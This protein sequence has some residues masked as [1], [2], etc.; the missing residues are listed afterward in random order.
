MRELLKNR[1]FLRF[2]S[3]R[4]VTNIG[5]SLYLIG[6]LWLVHDLTGSTLYTGAAGF[7]LRAPRLIQFLFGPLVDRWDLRKTL[8]GTQLIQGVF[9]LSLPV[10]SALNLLSVWLVLAVI[11]TLATVSRIQYPT[12]TA[13]L[14]RI[15][16]DDQLVRANSLF[17]MSGRTLDIVF[18]ATAGVLIAAVGVTQLFVIDAVTFGIATLLFLGV[19]LRTLE[20][21]EEAGGTPAATDGGEPADE[22]GQVAEYL[23]ELKEGIAY[24]RGSLLVYMGIGGMIANFGAGMMTAVFPAFADGFGGAEMYGFLMAAMATGTLVGAAGSWVVEDLP[25]GVFAIAGHVLAGVG[26][27]SA[28]FAHNQYLTPALLFVGLTPI[29]AANVL[30][31]SVLQS[32]VSDEYMGRVSAAFSTLTTMTLPLGS[33]AGGVIGS[34]FSPSIALYVLATFVGL[35]AAFFLLKE[36]LRSLPSVAE[37]DAATMQLGTSPD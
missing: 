37:I 26:I 8:I 10:A 22:E 28:V 15:V 13:M 7:L 32:S 33:V 21:P 5:D 12:Q 1:S 36:D 25:Y 20:Q 24:L 19:K 4:V 27:A 2:F 18:N 30:L 3:G 9:V 35:L 17:Q 34:A 6:A 11:P 29:G 14:P 23:T 31:G 16:E